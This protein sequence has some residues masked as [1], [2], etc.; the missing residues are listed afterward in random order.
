[1]GR[2]Q[3]AEEGGGKT[4]LTSRKAQLNISFTATCQD[5]TR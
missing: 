4:V 1:M 2:E 5:S 3:K